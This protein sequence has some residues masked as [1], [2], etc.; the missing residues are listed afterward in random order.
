MIPSSRDRTHSFDHARRRLPFGRHLWLAATLALG[1]AAT[2]CASRQVQVSSVGD[3]GSNMVAELN[4][5]NGRFNFRRS[6]EGAAEVDTIAEPAQKLWPFLEQVYD[7][8]SIPVHVRNGE[9]RVL[10]SVDFAATRRLGDHRLSLFLNCGSTITGSM[11]DQAELTMTVATQVRPA[12][13]AAKESEVITLVSA[14]A[15]QHGLSSSQTNCTS[16]R[17]LEDMILTR[18]QLLALGKRD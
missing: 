6:T 1:L 12:D 16:T 17:R 3:S 18:L 11:A 2:A 9:A 14:T 15:R 5:A 7:S 10:G 4:T 13:V 8:L